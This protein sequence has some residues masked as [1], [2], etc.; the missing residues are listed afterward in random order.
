MMVMMTNRMNSGAARH[1]C[2]ETLYKCSRTGGGASGWRSSAAG[3]SAPE[4]SLGSWPKADTD[5]VDYYL[6]ISQ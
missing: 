4:A 5:D 6:K 2:P 1:V 3:E